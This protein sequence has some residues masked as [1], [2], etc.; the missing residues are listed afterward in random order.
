MNRPEGSTFDTDATPRAPISPTLPERLLDRL[1]S[2]LPEDE[3]LRLIARRLL[4][5]SAQT[6]AVVASGNPSGERML[7]NLA[8]LRANVE[9]TA[10]ARFVGLLRDAFSEVLD[11]LL[12][13]VLPETT[14][15]TGDGDGDAED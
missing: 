8:A 7:G 12:G 15:E 9:S 10:A 2:E 5:L 4:L 6:W 1:E 11:E 3:E 14:S 13:Q